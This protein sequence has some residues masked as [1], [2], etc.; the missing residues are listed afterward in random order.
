MNDIARNVGPNSCL[1]IAK[2]FRLQWEP[3]QN[4][5][6]LLYPEGM[7]KLNQSAGEILKRCDGTRDI[8]ALIADLEHAFSTTGLGPEV[9]AFVADARGRGWLE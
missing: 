9:R 2:Q 1:T 5:H 3:A 4:A 6:V 8:D 7:V